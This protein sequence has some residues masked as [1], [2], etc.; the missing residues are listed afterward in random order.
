LAC[1]ALLALNLTAT[2]LV[3]AVI[4]MGA[5]L[6]LGVLA[7]GTAAILAATAIGVM[8]LQHALVRPALARP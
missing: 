8:R 1:F 7:G 4:P 6:L 2:A 3:G 5:T